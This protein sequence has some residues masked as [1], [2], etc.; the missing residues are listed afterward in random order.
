[1]QVEDVA[2]VRLTAGRAAQQQRHL[3]VGLGM[4][5]EVIEDNE[6]VA[7][8]LHELLANRRAGKGGQVL[9]GGRIGGGSADD[10]G[11]LHC[12]MLLQRAHHLG[13]ARLLLANAN[14]DADELFALLVDDGVERNRRLAR[15]SVTNDQLALAAANGHKCVHGADACLDG[16][17]DG[18]AFDDARGDALHEAILVGDNGPLAVNRQANCVDD[19]PNHGVTH[20]HLGNAPGAAH[21]VALFNGGVI[22][23]DDDAHL[24]GGEV[25][26]NAEDAGLGEFDQFGG[27]CAAQARDEGNAVADF[28]HLAHIHLAGLRLEVENLLPEQIGNLFS[29][30]SH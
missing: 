26:H 15:L 22:A 8:L 5:G 23:H 1:M 28:H 14:I 4:L 6:R 3:A 9:Q 27:H 19:A 2:G 13:N 29:L 24:I 12:A 10:N 18:L 11:V 20:G 25:E 17:V 21:K 7:P 30:Y 16:C